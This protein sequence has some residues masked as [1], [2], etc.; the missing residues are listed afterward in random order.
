MFTV[1]SIV[2]VLIIVSL[3][4]YNAYIVWYARSGRYEM[5]R[6]IDSATK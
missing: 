3:L 4:A 5:A 6:R 1:L 2:A